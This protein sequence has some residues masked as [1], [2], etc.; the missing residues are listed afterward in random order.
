MTTT[1]VHPEPVPLAVVRRLIVVPA[2]VTAPR[3]AEVHPVRVA[4]PV[5]VPL[6]S[7]I[8]LGADGTLRDQIA[9]LRQ[10]LAALRG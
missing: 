6:H 2:D 5:V 1:S 3:A 4:R 7:R 8:T 9:T 10:E